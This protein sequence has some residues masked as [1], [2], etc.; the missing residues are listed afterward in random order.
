MYRFC[1]KVKYRHRCFSRFSWPSRSLPG[2]DTRCAGKTESRPA[3]T[4][5]L[6]GKSV[7]VGQPISDAQRAQ[8]MTITPTIIPAKKKNSNTALCVR[9]ESS[10]PFAHGP[11]V[12]FLFWHSV[13]NHD[14]SPV[15]GLYVLQAFPLLGAH[16]ER[17]LYRRRVLVWL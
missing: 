7:W 8:P 14:E 15:E 2:W 10:C 13:R 5:S 9:E 16:V 3:L 6:T 1:Q 11:T 12:S 17:E 4:G